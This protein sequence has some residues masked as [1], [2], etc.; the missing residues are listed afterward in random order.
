MH[1]TACRPVLPDGR[2]AFCALDRHGYA[3]RGADRDTCCRGLE[4][5]VSNYYAG[6]WWAKGR[7]A[8]AQSSRSI[9]PH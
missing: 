8:R 3:P 4:V 7:L 2:H 5:G 6:E 9:P 1:G